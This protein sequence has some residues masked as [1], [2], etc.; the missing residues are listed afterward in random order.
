MH[1][2]TLYCNFCSLFDTAFHS[3]ICYNH[4]YSVHRFLRTTIFINFAIYEPVQSV[5]SETYIGNTY[6]K[7][8]YELRFLRTS[9]F[10]NCIYG[11]FKCLFFVKYN[12]FSEL[13]LKNSIDESFVFTNTRTLN[14]ILRV[15][16]LLHST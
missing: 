14:E 11:P 1:K 8:F 6:K 16:F 3:E 7:G 5:P 2:P 10:T 9:L 12:G 4:T 13:F 15:H